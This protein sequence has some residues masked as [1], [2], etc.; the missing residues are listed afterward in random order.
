MIRSSQ[1]FDLLCHFLELELDSITLVFTRTRKETTQLADRL[2]IAGYQAEALSGELSQ[3]L[4]EAVV[5]R[6]KEN[7]LSIVV[8]T[9]VAARGLDIEGISLVVNCDVPLDLDSYVHRVGRTGRA[10]RKGRALLFV[11]PREIKALERL[12]SFLE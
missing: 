4:R 1:R 5:K 8:A 9:D 12:E 3:N 7:R 10:G 11:T 6:L 2:Q